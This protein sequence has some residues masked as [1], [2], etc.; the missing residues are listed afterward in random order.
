MYITSAARLR[1]DITYYINKLRT[2]QNRRLHNNSWLMTLPLWCELNQLTCTTSSET[3]HIFK[4]GIHLPN[5]HLIFTPSYAIHADAFK[6]SIYCL[7]ILKMPLILQS[8]DFT[9]LSLLPLW[10]LQIT[11]WY[12]RNIL[13][14]MNNRTCKDCR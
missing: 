8:L 2:V 1:F 13:Y 5:D 4:Q 3:R 6:T 10:I 11:G 14:G 9:E 12:Y 7:P